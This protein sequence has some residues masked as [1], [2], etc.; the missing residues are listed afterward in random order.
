MQGRVVGIT[1]AVIRGANAEGIGLAISIDLAKPIVAE[2]IE[3]GQ[4]NRGF[5]GVSPTQITPDLAE[6]FQPRR[7]PRGEP[8]RSNVG[9]PRRPGRPAAGRHHR[10]DRRHRDSEYRRAVL[11][12]HQV[13]GGGN[14]DSGVLPRRQPPDHGGD[15]GRT[16]VTEVPRSPAPLW[17]G[18]D[19]RYSNG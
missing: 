18:S 6:T 3:E 5:L 9:E 4:V 13:P 19:S 15:V 10:Q 11:G 8:A 14:G 16:A 7:R 1:T 12:P 17:G 2:L